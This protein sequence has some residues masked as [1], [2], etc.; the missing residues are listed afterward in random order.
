MRYG[1]PWLFTPHERGAV[2][3]RY[4]VPW[5]FFPCRGYSSLAAICSYVVRLLIVFSHFWFVSPT[6]LSEFSP[7][8]SVHKIHTPCGEGVQGERLHV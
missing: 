6:E 8:V 1:V 7:N 2:A 4:G 3:L 5:L